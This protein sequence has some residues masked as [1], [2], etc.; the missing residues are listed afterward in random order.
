MH[1]ITRSM[2][3]ISTGERVKP[4]NPPRCPLCEGTLVVLHNSYRCSRCCYHLL[5]VGCDPVEPETIN[6]PFV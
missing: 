3:E 5:C 4:T 6:H 2:Q 1:I